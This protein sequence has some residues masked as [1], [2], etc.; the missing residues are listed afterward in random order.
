MRVVNKFAKQLNGKFNINGALAAVGTAVVI[1]GY[2]LFD[3]YGA[4]A[5]GNPIS[6][7]CWLYVIN[8]FPINVILLLRQRKTYIPYFCNRW[9]H[10]LFGGLCSLGS[11]GV[12]LWAMTKAPIAMV[13]ALR[14][15]SVIFGM[16]LAV[17]F[18]GEKF[19]AVKLLAVVLVATG[20]F[21]MH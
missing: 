3:G 17:F 8:T 14:E 6:Y 4:R 11:Y 9:K 20:I 21:F 12:A 15:T 2:T 13:A 7:V 16:L 10:G 18:L 5:S 19:S 1:M